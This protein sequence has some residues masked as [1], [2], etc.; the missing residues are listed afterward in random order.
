MEYRS[1]LDSDRKPVKKGGKCALKRKFP[2]II[3]LLFKL[4]TKR[5]IFFIVLIR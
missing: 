4:E 1:P 3:F 5:E 2:S